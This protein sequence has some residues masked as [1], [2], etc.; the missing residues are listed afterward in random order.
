MSNDMAQ[1]SLREPEQCDWDSAYNSSKYGAPPPASGPDGK[2][3]VYTGKLIEAKEIEN[4]DGYLNYQLD[5]TLGEG[6]VRT[7]ASTRP[8][9]RVNRETG[10]REP[11]RGNPNKLG[12]FLR[13]AGVQAKPQSNNEY[14]A[15][16][17]AVNGKLIPFTID[18]VAKNK[19]TGEEIKGFLS[20]PLDPAT[21]ERKTIL[22]AGDVYN[23]VDAQGNIIGTKT[24]QSEILF[25]NSRFRYF[26]D[27][28]R[29]TK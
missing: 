14:K 17:R 3:I 8:F 6:R 2:A 26:Q 21:G 16:I 9:T 12:S 5:F 19:D 27:A 4:E 18:W 24:V 22:R 15:S 28:T 10:E 20:F 25:A 23:E 13:A 29:G 11:M 1:Q 7:W